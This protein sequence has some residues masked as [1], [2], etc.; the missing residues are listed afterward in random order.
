MF[1]GHHEHSHD[2]QGRIAIPAA[3]RGELCGEGLRPFAP[4][5]NLDPDPRRLLAHPG[6]RAAAGVLLGRFASGGEMWPT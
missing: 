2:A 6:M 5:E 1:S 4:T 3:F